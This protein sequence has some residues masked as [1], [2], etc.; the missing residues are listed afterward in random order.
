MGSRLCK[1]NLTAWTDVVFGDGRNCKCGEGQR[2]GT[3]GDPT[4]AS[5]T[6]LVDA[7]FRYHFESK[8]GPSAPILCL[9]ETS[10]MP[11]SLTT[12]KKTLA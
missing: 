4:Q 8:G 3:R 2:E 1:L 9:G 5:L 11:L 7:P 6:Q 12:Q 10:D